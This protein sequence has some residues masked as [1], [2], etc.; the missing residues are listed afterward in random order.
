MIYDHHTCAMNEP[1]MCQECVDAL[2]A[3][4][5]QSEANSAA[6]APGHESQLLDEHGEMR[7]LLM[8]AVD[9]MRITQRLFELGDGH[10]LISQC[11][12]IEEWFE[13][14]Q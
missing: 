14:N 12:E 5:A 1:V 9:V 10:L 4:L 7:L 6:L 13:E 3:R 8:H 11:R 2:R